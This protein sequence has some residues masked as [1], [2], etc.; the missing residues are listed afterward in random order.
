MR[1]MVN[2]DMRRNTRD[3]MSRK[4]SDSECELVVCIFIGVSSVHT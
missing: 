4:V 2:A 1:K 3:N